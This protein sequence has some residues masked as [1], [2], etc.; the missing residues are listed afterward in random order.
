MT[1]NVMQVPWQFWFYLLCKLFYFAGWGY[2]RRGQVERKAKEGR[3]LEEMEMR[4]KWAREIGAN[5]QSV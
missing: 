5:N 4:R 2:G 3:G 1:T